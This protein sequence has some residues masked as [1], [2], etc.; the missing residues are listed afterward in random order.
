MSTQINSANP[1]NA[2]GVRRYICP[3]CGGSVCFDITKQQLACSSC[4]APAEFQLN[5]TPVTEHP[6]MA[7]AAD[8][9]QGRSAQTAGSEIT[10]QSCGAS[11]PLSAAQTAAVCPMCGAAH[12]LP[13]KQ[14]AGLPPDGVVPFK[15][16]RYKAMELLRKWI[17]G[18]WFAPNKL[19]KSY[20][21][22]GI[23]P[24]YLPFWSFAANA[25]AHYSGRGGRTRIVRRGKQ[26]T[27][28]TDWFPVS[29]LVRTSFTDLQICA[30]AQPESDMASG[31]TPF[32]G[33]SCYPY[34][35]AYLA[36]SE[37]QH[38]TVSL[39]R[40]YATAQGR[41][42][43][44]LRMLA[45]SDIRSKGFQLADVHHIDPS[46]SN[47]KY[48]QLLCPVWLSNFTYAGKT[49]QCAINGET[50]NVSGKRP[51]SPIKIAVAVIIIIICGLLFLYLFGDDSGQGGPPPRMG[52]AEQQIT[53][54]LAYQADAPEFSAASTSYTAQIAQN[55]S[56]ISKPISIPITGGV[57]NGIL[58]TGEID[59]R[60]AGISPGRSLL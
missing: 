27:T 7:G 55:S 50:G 46:Y 60:V 35:A 45:E 49:Y 26:T 13:E 56:Q 36:G 3:H 51:Y 44:E 34:D 29:G 19:K 4:G 40:G 31:V 10:C 8:A 54:Q 16:D 41:M 9:S 32:R 28:V 25:S 20:Q 39:D 15:V 53:Y 18:R 1:T 23:S 43:A 47:V 11:I 58:R 2:A 52:E 24:V 59:G 22:G 57:S 48:R 21:E 33:G 5:S 37:A 17:G 30:A 42:E 14:L 6:Y 38:Y 12:V